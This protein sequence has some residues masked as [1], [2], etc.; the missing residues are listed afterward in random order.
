MTSIDF[1][2][3]LGTA[4]PSR[5]RLGLYPRFGRLPMSVIEEIVNSFPPNE[6]AI[7]PHFLLYEQSDEIDAILIEC[8]LPVVIVDSQIDNPQDMNVIFTIDFLSL[9]QAVSVVTSKLEP[10]ENDRTTLR[11]SI[12]CVINTLIIAAMWT[13]R[14]SNFT[15]LELFCDF[16]YRQRYLLLCAFYEYHNI[17]RRRD[18]LTIR[19][20]TCKYLCTRTRMAGLFDQIDH[21]HMNVLSVLCSY[22]TSVDYVFTHNDRALFGRYAH[23]TMQTAMAALNPIPIPVVYIAEYPCA[24]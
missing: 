16:F 1:S 19:R 5:G 22:D 15:H 21:R 2:E 6:C 11:V 9:K 23:F 7:L 18:D 20:E 13:A 4:N 24:H 12:H 8:Q 17:I 10:D 3:M 14:Y